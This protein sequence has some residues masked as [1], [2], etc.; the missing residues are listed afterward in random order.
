MKLVNSN[1]KEI[2]QSK[3]LTK[4]AK[5]WAIKNWHYLTKVNTPLIN[6]NSSSKIAKGKKINLL[7]AIL[8][9]KPA[10]MVSTKTLCAGADLFGCKKDCLESSG[11]LGM[12]AGDNAKIKRT[13]LFLLRQNEFME[14]MRS[15]I[16]AHQKTAERKKQKFAVRLNGT[17]DI[18][19]SS[20]IESMPNITFYDYSK[21]FFR[22]KKNNLKNYDLTFSGSAKSKKVLAITARAI[23]A[24]FRTVLAMNTAETKGEYKLPNK[25]DLIPL[26]NMDDTDARFLDDLSAV[27]VLARKGSNKEQRQKDETRNNFF[28]NQSTINQLGELL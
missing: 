16:L 9:L 14:T 4:S 26:I 19:F 23:K 1:Q 28:F 27:G 13:I 7:T 2:N 20:F 21:V 10:D 5:Q 18:D 3:L 25:L 11:Q 6:V 8:Y 24:G 17:S 12:K 22:L 15:E